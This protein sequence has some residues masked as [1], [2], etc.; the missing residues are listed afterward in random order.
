MCQC[1]HV[2]QHHARAPF[3]FFEPVSDFVHSDSVC[4]SLCQSASPASLSGTNVI[5]FNIVSFEARAMVPVLARLLYKKLRYKLRQ[6]L[7]IEMDYMHG[8][9]T[10]AAASRNDTSD[11]G[12][13]F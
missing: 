4:H 10:I 2:S 7:M 3:L 1:R 12:S 5:I 9:D 13:I 11:D 6:N 8:D